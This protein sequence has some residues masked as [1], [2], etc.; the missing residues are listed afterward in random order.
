MAAEAV[1]AQA[2]LELLLYQITLVLAVAEH[3]I[4]ILAAR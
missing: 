3:L 2:R 1:V 4:H